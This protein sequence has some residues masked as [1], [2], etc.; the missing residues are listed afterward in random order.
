M[1]LDKRLTWLPVT[2][3]DEYREPGDTHYVDARN[4]SYYWNPMRK[5]LRRYGNGS[6]HYA[7]IPYR[8]RPDPEYDLIGALGQIFSRKRKDVRYYEARDHDSFY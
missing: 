5:V 1:P 7:E 3:N 6:N 2:T 8:H 4:Y